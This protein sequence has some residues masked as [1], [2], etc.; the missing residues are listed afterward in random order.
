MANVNNG[1]IL[2]AYPDSLGGHLAY[3]T[4]LLSSPALQGAFDCFYILPSLF[5]Y[6]LDRGFS[7]IS[8][9][10]NHELADASQLHTLKENGISLKLDLVLNHLS[11]LSPQFQSIL[12]EG[13]QSPY[14]DFFINWNDFWAHHGKMTPEGY[15]QPDQELIADMFFRKPGL[16][17]LMV[18]MP[19][20]KNVPYWN[21]FY[22]DIRYPRLDAQDVMACANIQYVRAQHLAERINCALDEGKTPEQIDWTND[23]DTRESLCN[24]L[25][26]HRK[27]L[28]QMDVNLSSEKVWN[29][30]R[31]TIR[32]LADYGAS[33]IRL[34]A[35]A[36]AAKAL[37]KRNFFNEPETWDALERL[38]QIAQEYNLVLL[39]EIHATYTE[40]LY[41]K[42]AQKGYAVYDFFLPGLLIDAIENHTS[43]FLSQWAH[44]L[45]EKQIR[46]VN[47]LGCHDGIPMLDLRGLLPMERIQNLIDLMVSRGGMVKDLH[48]QKNMYYQVN[49]TYYSALGMDDRKLLLARAVQLFMPGKPQVWY[50]DLLAGSNDYDAVLHG[51]AAGH[52]EI[53]RTNLTREQTESAL[54]KPVVQKQLSLLRMRNMSPAF[55]EDAQCKIDTPSSTE[56]SLSWLKGSYR[57]SLHVDFASCTFTAEADLPRG[58]FY[59]KA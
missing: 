19:D 3:I 59:M 33:I 47:M 44:E 12:K 41:L 27:Y 28:G 31:E 39:P 20:G 1:T 36:Y 46:T 38:R 43:Q 7:I 37:G 8:Y 29:F 48:G 53:N 40:G 57:A 32:Q 16:P 15:I 35:F 17:L 22:Q 55:S 34:D 54:Q 30:Y 2:N 10:I 13:K 25:E 18:R 11:V 9:D 42:L 51:G 45:L 4:E 23:T 21:T 52:K 50:L 14:A 24:Y 58:S 26:S 49:T 5:N 56:L 6:D